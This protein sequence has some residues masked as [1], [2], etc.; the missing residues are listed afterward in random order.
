MPKHHHRKTNQR[1]LDDCSRR[2][3]G[4]TNSFASQRPLRG[5]QKGA[6]FSVYAPG[7]SQVGEQMS[8]ALL[9]SC[10]GQLAGTAG[11]QAN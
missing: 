7:D 11:K 6:Q 4:E 2:L 8:T 5:V 9:P 1:C 3:E 10:Q